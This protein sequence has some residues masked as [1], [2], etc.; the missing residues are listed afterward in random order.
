MG[1]IPTEVIIHED[2]LKR[3]GE[4]IKPKSILRPKPPREILLI[5][6]ES[7]GVF[8]D[9]E[10]F[11]D[12]GVFHDTMLINFMPVAWKGMPYEHFVAGDSHMKQMQDVA[13]EEVPRSVIKHCWNPN[14][15]GFNVRWV[16]KQGGWNGTTGN[17][18]I[19]IGLQLDYTRIVLAGVPMDTTGNWYSDVLPEDDI[20]KTKNHAHHLWKWTEIACR[21]ISHFIRSMSGNT[22]ELF[23][24]PDDKWLMNGKGE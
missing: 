24:Y 2:P 16:R 5:V 11:F 19:Q 1:I 20:K 23:G 17:L 18:A 14:S 12:F 10:A 4:T 9:V 22:K 3:M 13:I 8:E 7:A 15:L 6:G 21:P